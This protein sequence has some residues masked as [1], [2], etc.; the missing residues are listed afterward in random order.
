M[1]EFKPKRDDYAAAVR[2]FHDHTPF[3]LQFGI[4][5]DEIKPGRVK[6]S[7]PMRREFVQQ[8]DV[9]HAG[10]LATLADIVCGLASY[11]LM[12]EGEN[13]LSVHF[14][15]SLMRAATGSRMWADGRVVKPGG[16]LHFTEAEVYAG[17]ENG[18]KLVAKAAITMAVV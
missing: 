8:T 12:A 11:S 15:I 5:L 13:V 2:A 10:V 4:S 6:A 18:G 16:R 1:T 9:A 17:D 7:M 14:S 3:A